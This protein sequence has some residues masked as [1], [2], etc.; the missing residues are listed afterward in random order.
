MVGL[1]VPAHIAH[2]LHVAPAGQETGSCVLLPAWNDEGYRT[3]IRLATGL[4]AAGIGSYLLEAPFY[5]LRRIAPGS[6]PVRTVA[7]FATLTR[8]VV[9]EG[10]SLVAALVAAGR[11]TGVAGYSMGGSLAATV[12]ATLD[13]PIAVAPL[14]AAHA[15]APVFTSGV[16]RNAVA[17]DALGPDG[18]ERLTE[19]LLRPSLLRLPPSPPTRCAVLV[20]A[21]GDGFV[22]P[23]ATK[24]IHEHWP[25]SELRVVRAGHATLLWRHVD[26]L[27][28][29]TAHAFARA[30]AAAS[31]PSGEAESRWT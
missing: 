26:I 10:R 24:A 11:R 7:D 20:A 25:G 29:A 5:G 9:E 13:L 3:R 19:V 12:A 30:A 8:S 6:S 31:E 22:A 2:V 4:A 23:A 16:L 15:P 18:R 28:S 21:S 14:A 17:W 1:P 27:V